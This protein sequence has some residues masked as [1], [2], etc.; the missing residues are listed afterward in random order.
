MQVPDWPG[1]GCPL[2]WVPATATMPASA[3]HPT[4]NEHR[5]PWPQL[6]RAV[7]ACFGVAVIQV[8][9]LPKSSRHCEGD[10]RVRQSLRATP[11]AGDPPKSVA[12]FCALAPTARPRLRTLSAKRMFRPAFSSAAAKTQVWPRNI[13]STSVVVS[14]ALLHRQRAGLS[15]ISVLNIRPC[16]SSASAS[17]TNTP[18]LRASSRRRGHGDCVAV[19]PQGHAII[20]D[21]DG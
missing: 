20:N 16:R 4:A 3:Q 10:L 13:P 14:F 7:G 18:A 19:Q 5:R 21:R 17:L 11:L 15:T 12:S 6:R 1:R 2:D 8:I 9:F